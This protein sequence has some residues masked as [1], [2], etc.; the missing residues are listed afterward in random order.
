MFELIPS[1]VQF[2]VELLSQALTCRVKGGSSSF[3]KIMGKCGSEKS[4]DNLNGM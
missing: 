3:D 4:K 2:A 1:P